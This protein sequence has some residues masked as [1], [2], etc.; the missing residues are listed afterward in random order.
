MFEVMNVLFF[1]ILFPFG[2]LM[3]Q[4][5]ILCEVEIK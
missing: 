5:E 2:Q 1:D 3:N 4:A